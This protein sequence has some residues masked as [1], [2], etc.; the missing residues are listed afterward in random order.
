M[1]PRLRT[2]TQDGLTN[3]KVGW[4]LVAACRSLCSRPISVAHWHASKKWLTLSAQSDVLRGFTDGA[5][6]AAAGPNWCSVHSYEDIPYD[7]H[8][9]HTVIMLQRRAAVGVTVAVG[10]EKL[11]R[12]HSRSIRFVNVPAFPCQTDHPDR[13]KTISVLRPD[14]LS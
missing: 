2:A 9:S 11:F 14:K 6:R 8:Q 7:S 12:Y 13:D 5:E 10:C 1:L 3:G 4:A